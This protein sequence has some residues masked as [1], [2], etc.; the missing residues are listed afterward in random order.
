M[1]ET[2]VRL[3]VKNPGVSGSTLHIQAYVQNPLT[4]L[5]LSTGFDLTST[6]GPNTW[7]PSAPLW[8]PN[9]LGGLLGTQNVTLVF[10]TKGPATWGI[11][12]VYIDPFRSR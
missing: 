1:G 12:D 5:V 4:G 6:S 10:T 3:F 9:L 11:D 2:R 7:A 8:I